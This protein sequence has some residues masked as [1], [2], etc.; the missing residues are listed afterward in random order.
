MKELGCFVMPRVC[1]KGM[2]GFSRDLSNPPA[3]DRVQRNFRA[4]NGW[5]RD[6]IGKSL[7][8][9]NDDLGSLGLC[10]APIPMPVC[11]MSASRCA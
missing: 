6:F 10:I 2:L 3:K 1:S 8:C 5:V 7:G 11:L 9:A 4:C